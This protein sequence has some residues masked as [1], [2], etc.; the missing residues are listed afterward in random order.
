ML[1]LF[2]SAPIAVPG[3]AGSAAVW[4][5]IGIMRMMSVHAAGY[6]GHSYESLNRYADQSASRDRHNRGRPGPRHRTFADAAR[7]RSRAGSADQLW[8]KEMTKTEMLVE[9]GF[10]MELYSYGSLQDALHHLSRRSRGA[11]K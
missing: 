10:R 2:L 9:A 7:S 5:S 3:G 11:E 1:A 4:D 8:R 6:G